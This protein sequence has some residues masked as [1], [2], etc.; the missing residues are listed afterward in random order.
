VNTRRIVVFG[1]KGTL[2]TSRD[3]ESGFSQENREHIAKI[4]LRRSSGSIVAFSVV[5]P[6]A[7]SGRSLLHVPETEHIQAITLRK[8]GRDL[9]I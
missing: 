4:R 3:E 9:L 7:K 8:F 1:A 5:L 2:L 6:G